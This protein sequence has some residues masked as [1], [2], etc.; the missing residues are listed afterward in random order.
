LYQGQ[1]FGEMALL[2]EQ[3]RNAT[4]VCKDTKK[5]YDEILGT[6]EF[7]GLMKSQNC[8]EENPGPDRLFCFIANIQISYKKECLYADP[9]F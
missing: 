5:D 2:L 6:N 4:I 1:A 8:D 3:P 9:S 7:S